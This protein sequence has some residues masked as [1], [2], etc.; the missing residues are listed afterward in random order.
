MASTTS[1]FYRPLPSLSAS[2]TTSKPA[3][4]LLFSVGFLNKPI[5]LI[6]TS[7]PSQ[8]RSTAVVVRYR[9]GSRRV[10]VSDDEGG[11]DDETV[12]IEADKEE[13]EYDPN[14]DLERI[15]S[16]T[17][18]LL[19]EQNN[20]I[21]V[22]SFREAVRKSENSGLILA[23]VSVDADPPV[24]R[25]FDESYY[26]KHKFEKQKKKKIQQK[27]SSVR[28]KEVKMGYRIDSHDYSVRLKQGRKF[29]KEGHKV[30]AIVNMKGRENM[31]RTTAVELLRQFQ[32][33]LGKM[34][35]EESKNF[36]DKNIYIVLKPNK[37]NIQ[38]EAQL[39]Q[40]EEALKK[41]ESEELEEPIETQEPVETHNSIETEEKEESVETEE[42]IEIEEKEEA[43]ETEATSTEEVSVNV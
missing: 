8:G 19:D 40:K 39:K 33:D 16:P 28:T 5:G 1:F 2:P 26:K 14:L 41:K 18:R 15:E 25:L 27:Q 34:A 31:Y 17:V 12:L 32:T 3:S 29:L 37:A 13:R 9:G 20:M 23:I 4:N 36:E 35:I 10:P 11:E 30:K 6:S 7:P 42:P 22:M 38:R 21:G 43:V 24:V